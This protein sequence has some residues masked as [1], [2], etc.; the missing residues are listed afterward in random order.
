MRAE[1]TSPFLLSLS[2][3]GYF[4]LI[5]FMCF[6]NECRPSTW[7][8]MGTTSSYE[9]WVKDRPVFRTI[10]RELDDAGIEALTPL[11]RGALVERGTASDDEVADFVAHR[12]GRI[13]SAYSLLKS[14]FFSGLQKMSLP[15]RVDGAPNFRRVPLGAVAASDLAQSAAS[16]LSTAQGHGPLVYGSGMPTVDGLRHALEK[17]SARETKVLWQSLREEPVLFVS[18]R[19]H[20][21]RLFDRPL[22]N[23]ITTGVTTATVEAM[24]VELKKDLLREREKTGGKVLLV[25]RLSLWPP[26]QIAP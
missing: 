3:S 26:S 8:E 9:T 13:L 7:R 19:P 20:V 12:D 18:G 25:R 22:E 15:E 1:L 14:D 21:L 2:C 24:E 17:M 11:S 16:S 10:Q 5:L 4:F 23:V 6:L